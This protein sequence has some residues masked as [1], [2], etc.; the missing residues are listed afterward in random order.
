MEVKEAI[1][2]AKSYV[3]NVFDGDK[4]QNL[5]LEEIEFD[6][7]NQLWIVTVG[8]SRPWDRR[9]P[10]LHDQMIGNYGRRDPYRPNRDYKVVSVRDSDGKVVSVR[11]YDNAA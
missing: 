11:N 3:A 8:F 2:A 4:I 7:T 9:T 10:T 5:G 1:A 6:D